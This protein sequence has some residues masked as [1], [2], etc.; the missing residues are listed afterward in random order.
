MLLIFKEIYYI[1]ILYERV[2]LCCLYSKKST[3]KPLDISNWIHYMYKIF[4]DT[5]PRP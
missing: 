1:A 4:L 5:L 2:K 3:M